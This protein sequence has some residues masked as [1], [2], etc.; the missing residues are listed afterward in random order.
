MGIGICTLIESR[1]NGNNALMQ[2]EV[3]FGESII[4][5]TRICINGL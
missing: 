5:E 1:R 2:H 3:N 4:S